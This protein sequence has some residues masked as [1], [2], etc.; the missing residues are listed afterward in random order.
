MSIRYIVPNEVLER[1]VKLI[2]LFLFFSS[3][4]AIKNN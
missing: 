2:Y 4:L 1:I 3:K